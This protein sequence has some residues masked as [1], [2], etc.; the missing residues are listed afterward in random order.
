MRYLFHT[1]NSI[2]DFIDPALSHILSRSQANE[3]GNQAISWGWQCGGFSLSEVPH[4]SHLSLPAGVQGRGAV[5]SAF[6]EEAGCLLSC[7]CCPKLWYVILTNGH[8][9]GSTDAKR[10]HLITRFHNFFWRAKNPNWGFPYSVF[11]EGW[12]HKEI[13]VCDFWVMT[14]LLV[15]A[16][17]KPVLETWDECKLDPGNCLGTCLILSSEIVLLRSPELPKCLKINICWHWALRPPDP[18]FSQTWMKPGLGRQ[19]EGLP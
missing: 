7:S 9:L 17:A 11:A 8:G 14:K 10:F 12:W 6:G 19:R 4:K 3:M 16:T 2:N 1:S 13:V 5:A 15:K 18:C